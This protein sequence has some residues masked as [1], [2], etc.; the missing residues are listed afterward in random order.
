MSKQNCSLRLTFNE[1]DVFYILNLFKLRTK[2]QSITLAYN[3]TDASILIH[4]N[5]NFKKIYNFRKIMTK[6]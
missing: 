2:Q 6:L 4:K 3:A 1:N 5:N